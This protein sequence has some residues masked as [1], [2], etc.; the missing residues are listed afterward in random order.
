MGPGFHGLAGLY[1]WRHG[2]PQKTKKLFF[3]L[4][5]ACGVTFPTS[6]LGL[7][8]YSLQKTKGFILH[9]IAI[10]ATFGFPPLALLYSA[11][12]KSFHHERDYCISACLPPEY[13]LNPQF[14]F[15]LPWTRPSVG[16]PRLS[17]TSISH[18]VLVG[19]SH[20]FTVPYPGKF[21]SY[22]HTRENSTKVFATFCLGWVGEG[23]I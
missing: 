7:F 14:H 19:L 10:S 16:P 13:P 1:V 22:H 20:C 11:V 18:F 15:P 23:H 6:A 17:E 4:V 21:A 9:V 8:F 12:T 3:S 2:G 5:C